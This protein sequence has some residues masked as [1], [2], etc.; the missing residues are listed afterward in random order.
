M[1]GKRPKHRRVFS[2]EILPTVAHAKNL[3]ENAGIRAEIR[4]ENL[5]S[6]MGEVPFFEVWP[7]LWVSQDEDVAPALEIIERMLS[8][9]NSGALP[10][11]C[12]YCKADNEPQFA[13]C[14]QCSR[15]I[16]EGE[17]TP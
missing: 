6:L 11:Q 7:E 9:D 4:N 8:T 3:L 1:F 12:R 15:P 17:R 16:D 2:A 5:G 13:A 10:W 14:W